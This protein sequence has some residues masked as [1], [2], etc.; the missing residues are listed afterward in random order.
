MSES[1]DGVVTLASAHSAKE[2]ADRLGTAA[3]G[4]G[5]QVFCRVDHAANA[6]EVGLDLRPTELLIFGHARGGT[7]LMLD[8]QV[9]G[10]D[11]PVRALAWEDEAGGVWLSYDD[12][13]WLA[14]RH[15]LGPA[16]ADAVTALHD[17]VAHLAAAA[18][19]G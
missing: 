1:S 5:L 6:A 18:T 7:P 4:A 2:T 10:L 16:S 17:G 11:L 13:G 3:T 8:R 12:V 14:A 15:G 9:I 19:A